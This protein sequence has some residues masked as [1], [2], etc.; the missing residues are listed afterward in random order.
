M[1]MNEDEN[2]IT[3]YVL[4]VGDEGYSV[5]FNESSFGVHETAE[6]L[7]KAMGAA[8][9][10]EEE[11]ANIELFQSHG[12]DYTKYIT[13]KDDE[14]N[15]YY[16][17]SG[18][19]D[20]PGEDELSK[21]EEILHE[22]ED[23]SGV[24]EEEMEISEE[25]QSETTDAGDESEEEV[26]SGDVPAVHVKELGGKW[27]IRED[28]KYGFRALPL[29]LNHLKKEGHALESIKDLDEAGQEVAR[30]IWKRDDS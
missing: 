13:M 19:S 30:L 14:K 26:E 25:I 4:N 2:K 12:V 5:L 11:I 21:D 7:A 3:R 8:G 15:E 20:L 1:V 9:V 17:L 10:L 16:D 18:D 29:L 23:T 6:G 28:P 22:Q 24:S 27:V